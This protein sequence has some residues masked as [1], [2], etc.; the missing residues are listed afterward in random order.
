MSKIKTISAVTRYESVLRN[1]RKSRLPPGYPEPQPPSV[2]PAENVDLLERYLA[3][4]VA[5]GAGH[6]CTMQHYIPMAGHVLGYHLKPHSQ[7]DLQ[8]DLERAMDYVLAKKPCAA[9][10][11]MWRVALRRFHHFLLLERGIEE[12]EVKEISAV[13]L[14]QYQEGIPA[15]LVTQLTHLQ[16]LRQANWRLARQT[17]AIRNFWSTYIRLWRW[18]FAHDASI[19]TTRDVKRQHVFA[20]ID[21]RLATGYSPKS[22]NQDL[23]AFQASLRF[24]QERDFQVPQAL[25]RIPGLKEPDG[26][27]RFLTDEQVSKVQAVLEQQVQQA[28]NPVQQR[29]A[30]L[31]RAAFY[32]LWQSG[33]RLAEVEELSVA[34]LNLTQRQMMIRQGKGQKDRAVYLTDTAVTALKAYLTVRGEGPSD[35]LFLFRHKPLPKDFLRRRMKAAGKRAGIK[36]TPHQLRHTYA[37]QLLNAGCK[38]T[39]IQALMGHKFLSTTLTYARVHDRTVAQDYYAAMAVVE[40]RLADQLPPPDRNGGENSR[41]PS[42]N[43]TTHLLKLVTTL[44]AEP[45]TTTQ[46]ALVRELQQGLSVLA[47][48]INGTLKQKDRIVNEQMRPS[49][50]LLPIP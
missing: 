33:L 47:K 50:Q 23:W 44:Q 24:L 48:P 15:W 7:L 16:H 25:L 21:E 49:P 6:T 17:E 39:T 40:K 18:L 9:W 10:A 45:L 37:T 8:A 36:F 13:S 31:D 27:P 38:I 43:S 35:H 30:L 3:W 12:V 46:Q 26:L 41:F 22:V 34:D 32:L 2:W 28:R 29:N 19:Q 11:N 42:P 1:S 14:T 5:D 4:L 20:Y